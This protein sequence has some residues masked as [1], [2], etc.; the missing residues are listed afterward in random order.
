MDRIDLGIQS[1]TNCRAEAS[2]AHGEWVSI[3]IRFGQAALSAGAVGSGTVMQYQSL[4]EK[5]AKI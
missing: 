1:F 4:I 2:R 5:V 3:T